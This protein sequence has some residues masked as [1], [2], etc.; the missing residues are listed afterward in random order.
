MNL[1]TIL[2][3]ADRPTL[4]ATDTLWHDC[5][6]M[7]V[8]TDAALTHYARLIA[9]QVA[10]TRLVIP[11]T[12]AHR[13]NGS[14]QLAPFD[15]HT[16]GNGQTP[17]RDTCKGSPPT[18]MIIVDATHLPSIHVPTIKREHRRSGADISIFY[19]TPETDYCHEHIDTDASGLV[20]KTVREYQDSCHNHIAP[21][22]PLA[23][24]VSPSA[25]DLFKSCR[26]ENFE[27][28]V[29]SAEPPIRNRGGIVRWVRVP[30][31]AAYPTP[32]DSL[33]AL[34]MQTVAKN[35]SAH[36]P[37]FHACRL[38]GPL[39]M[40]RNVHIEPDVII[41]GPTAIG[42]H[43]T[44]KKGA[45]LNRCVV[46][47]HI[48]IQENSCHYRAILGTSN[49]HPKHP[50]T[51]RSISVPRNT[52]K[53]NRCEK[54]YKSERLKR[55]IDVIAATAGLL[56]LS[57]LF[58]LTALIIKATSPGPVFYSHRRQGR[59]GIE[60]HCW[61]FRTMMNDAEKL[62]ATL[63]SK[64][65]VDGP[66]FKIVD[67]PRV[68]RVGK[69][70]RRTNIDEL[71]QLYNVLV[72]HMSLIGPRPSPDNENQCCPA[73]RRARLSVRPGITGLWQVT[74]SNDRSQAD[75]QQWIYYD[76][77]YVENRSIGLDTQIMWQT[78]RVV[79]RLGSS[80][81]WQTRWAPKNTGHASHASGT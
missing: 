79:L 53:Q 7:P 34:V 57:P 75:F 5:L 55:C 63:R 60:F 20:H 47:P 21:R 4:H 38:D 18:E 81:R 49:G 54:V 16:Y 24:V 6:L 37:P 70:L 17:F 31:I 61:K 58:V 15:V 26:T 13:L 27:E 78:V 36:R 46:L 71:P 72:G 74:R 19:N 41:V 29:Q 40:G 50:S 30:G 43:V 9:S 66:Q 59:N 2:F 42:D 32:L 33:L 76:L 80:S 8:G 3:V 67:D 69:F 62:Q 22:I 77:Q 56:F 68:T 12:I 14:T 51:T 39:Q 23:L 48:T 65:Q 25:F 35:G 45:V 10:N 52:Q 28:I 44:V 1:K 73:W 64:N 11:T